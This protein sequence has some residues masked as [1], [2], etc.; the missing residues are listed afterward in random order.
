M[1]KVFLV[2]LGAFLPF[3]LALGFARK[4]VDKGQEFLPTSSE[5]FSLLLSMPDFTSYVNDD[6]QAVND[7]WKKTED[8]WFTI[9]DGE[10]YSDI[11]NDANDDNFFQKLGDTFK[12]LFSQISSFFSCFVPFFQMIGSTFV[13]VGHAITIPFKAVSWFWS[14]ILGLS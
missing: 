13:L 6:I 7:Y 1:K 8:T 5:V 10:D 12:V 3:L 2:I 9:P 11:W 4:T 14:G